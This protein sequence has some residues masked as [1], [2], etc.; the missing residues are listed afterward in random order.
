MKSNM[1]MDDTFVKELAVKLEVARRNAKLTLIDASEKTHVSIPTIRNYENAE[2]AHPSAVVLQILASAYG[3][4][5]SYFFTQS[6]VDDNE[7]TIVEY[8]SNKPLIRVSKTLADIPEQIVK[9]ILYKSGD[10]LPIVPY[11]SIVIFRPKEQYHSGDIVVIQSGYDNISIRQ[12]ESKKD[13]GIPLNANFPI[14]QL[15]EK[16]NLILGEVV[17]NLPLSLFSSRE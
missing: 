16:E 3:V 8:F 17:T 15:S 5:I 7:L 2:T 4:P 9:C 6:P 1:I 11:K 10:M 13:I 14:V 12:Y